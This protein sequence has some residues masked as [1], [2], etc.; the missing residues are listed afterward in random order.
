MAL[1]KDMSVSPPSGFIGRSKG[2][3]IQADYGPYDGERLL[4]LIRPAE[5]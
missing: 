5:E 4:R 1:N 3:T 2:D